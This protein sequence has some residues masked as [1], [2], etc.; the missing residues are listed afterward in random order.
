[1]RQQGTACNGLPAVT[2]KSLDFALFA[3]LMKQETLTIATRFNGPPGSGN[4]GYVCGL[5]AR[6]I[7]GPS[8]ATL[9]MPP[10]LER[11][12]TLTSDGATA[13]LHDGDTLI[14]DANAAPLF[15]LEPPPAPSLDEARAAAKRYVGFA[16]HRY[17]TCFVCG[18][19]R[20][21]HDG[22]D[23]FTGK[24]EGR[25]MVACAWTPRA[26]LAD[27]HGVVA[28][29]FIHAALDCPSYWALAYA[30]QPALLARLTASIDAPLPRIGEEL[31]IA[32]W[33]IR[34]DGRKHW[35]ASA[36]YHANGRIIARTEAL[37][38]EPKTA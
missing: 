38:I 18:P 7:D 8:E 29:E 19:S 32:G 5:L 10:P 9:R 31:I 6:G 16:D 28:E 37:W 30:G 17:D 25:D 2:C 36:L 11:T 13:A 20:P 4:G 14:G 22:L 35:G 15:A 26:D 23:V 21:A 12:L 27:T 34:S 1:M 24:V 33:P 3:S